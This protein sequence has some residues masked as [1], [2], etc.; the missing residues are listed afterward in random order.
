MEIMLQVIHSVTNGLL[1]SKVIVDQ[2]TGSD[3]IYSKNQGL[4][5]YK[6]S[7]SCQKTTKE[8]GISLESCRDQTQKKN[9]VDV[10][11]AS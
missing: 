10:C 4:G 9:R 7:F 1:D 2:L 11:V 8:V 3:D 6:P 5:T